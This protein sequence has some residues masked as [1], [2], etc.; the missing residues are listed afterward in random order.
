MNNSWPILSKQ[1]GSTDI[2]ILLF[3]PLQRGIKI[4]YLSKMDFSFCCGGPVDHPLYGSCGKMIPGY[5]LQRHTRSS[6]SFHAIKAWRE[7][8][9]LKLHR[10]SNFL[11]KTERNWNQQNT[12]QLRNNSH[13]M[14]NGSHTRHYQ[15]GKWSKLLKVET[16]QPNTRLLGFEKYVLHAVLSS[17]GFL[18]YL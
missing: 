6:S 14:G 13:D 17:G 8:W 15:I 5:P 4:K 3:L 1:G 18:M 11:P 2:L 7:A 10:K 9:K 16:L 12:W